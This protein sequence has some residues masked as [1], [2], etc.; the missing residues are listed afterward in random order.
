MQLCAHLVA[1]K[2]VMFLD[3]CIDNVFVI[4][5]ETGLVCYKLSMSFLK[6]Q[7]FTITNMFSLLSIVLCDVFR[8]LMNITAIFDGS[9][10]Q[11]T[12]SLSFHLMPMQSWH[13][14]LKIIHDIFSPL[15]CLIPVEL[16]QPY[17]VDSVEYLEALETVTDKLETRVNFCK[18]HLMMITCFDVS[19]RQ[20]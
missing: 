15:S 5:Y 7:S 9:K 4:T 19:S 2:K 20:R 6:M 16:Q 12:P 3:Q 14:Y 11:N 17:E 1:R 8:N 10:I 13:N 18:A